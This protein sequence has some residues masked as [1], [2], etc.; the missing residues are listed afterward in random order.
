LQFKTEV[1]IYDLCLSRGEKLLVK[2]LNLKLCAGDGLELRGANGSGKSTLLRAIAG[3]H[4]P[5]SGK[6]LVEF[7][8]DL[9]MREN[10]I[11]LG[12]KDG[13]QNNETVANQL[14]FWALFFGTD[15]AA[16]NV[17]IDRL[18]IASLARLFGNVLSAGQRQRVALARLLISNRAIWLLDEP[19]APLDDKGRGLLASIMNDHRND[20][21]IVVVAAHDKPQGGNYRTLLLGDS[22]TNWSLTS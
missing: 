19:A 7:G 5:L 6:I 12:H 8:G 17:A 2:N 9:T 18:G 3:L 13:V 20:G 1:S 21:G 11:V 22:N 15:S 10:L 14:R 16:V 4:R